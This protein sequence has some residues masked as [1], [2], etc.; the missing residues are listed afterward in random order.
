MRVIVDTDVW[1]EA[2]RNPPKDHSAHALELSELIQNARV[3]MIGFIRMEIL[4]GIREKKKFDRLKE[5]ISAFP[6]AP[7]D[8]E[9]FL[10][11]ASMFNLCRSKGVQG[12]M[13]DLIVCACSVL[14]KM[15]ILTKDKD[16]HNYRKLIPIELHLPR[17]KLKI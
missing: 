12:S 15:P 4:C 5:A 17:G 2:L 14:W 16:Y 6:D 9:V 10:A 7:L 13:T 3:Q 1:S 11:A 8:T